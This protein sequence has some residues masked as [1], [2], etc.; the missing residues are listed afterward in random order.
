[1]SILIAKFNRNFNGKTQIQFLFS[2]KF[3]MF[4]PSLLRL[5]FILLLVYYFYYQLTF[6]FLLALL[7]DVAIAIVIVIDIAITLSIFQFHQQS[8]LSHLALLIA[9]YLLTISFAILRHLIKN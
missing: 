9:T 8:L 3:I 5:R 4:K 1:M 7:F 6:L 2:V